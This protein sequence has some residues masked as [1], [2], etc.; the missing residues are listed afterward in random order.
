M[1]RKRTQG[2]SQRWDSLFLLPVFSWCHACLAFTKAD[3]KRREEE[4]ALLAAMEE[5]RKAKETEAITARKA[6][7]A[8]DH[9]L[10]LAEEAKEAMEQAKEA[11]KEAQNAKKALQAASE[12]VK[13]ESEKLYG[14]SK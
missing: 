4:K 10:R 13:I 7:D 12:K 3:L 14:K 1:P 5:E 11:E 2:E 8:M 9:A 6:K